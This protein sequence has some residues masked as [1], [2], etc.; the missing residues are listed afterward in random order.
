[1]E[2]FTLGIG[3]YAEDDVKEAA[4][5]LTGWTVRQGEFRDQATA[6]DDGE[7]QILGRTGTWTGDDL[8]KILLDQPATARRLAWRATNEFFGEGVVDE[9]ALD[10]L[11]TALVKH[12]LDIRWLVET[13]LRSELFFA[14]ANIHSRVCD[15]VSFVMGPLRALEC[16]RNSPSTL[17]LAEW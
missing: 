12:N 7:K 4:R 6:H 1:M 9:P 3:H 5:A 13:I 2:L 11:A 17:V 14:P 10:E 16:W 15:P 8:T